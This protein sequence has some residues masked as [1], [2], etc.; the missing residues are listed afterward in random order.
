MRLAAGTINGLT[1]GKVA[2]RPADALPKQIY[3]GG[4]F[5]VE[6]GGRKAQLTHVANAHT[7]GDTWI[8]FADANVLATGDTFNSSSAIRTSTSPTAATYAA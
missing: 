5:A 3:F 4:S 7:D 6:T 1:G 2:P 8:Y